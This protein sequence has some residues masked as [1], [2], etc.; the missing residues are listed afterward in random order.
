M[1][2]CRC[3]FGDLVL[4]IAAHDVHVAISSR[5]QKAFVCIKCQDQSECDM[6]IGDK[7]VQPC[8]HISQVSKLA[9]KNNDQWPSLCLISY[10]TQLDSP[11]AICTHPTYPV[12]N[13]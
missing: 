3:V 13:H 11:I 10:W 2:I 8:T 5:A 9:G 12:L 7:P 1:Y 4:L 6:S